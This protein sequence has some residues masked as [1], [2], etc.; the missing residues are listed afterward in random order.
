MNYI[1][2][3]R[4]FD[5]TQERGYQDRLLRL[6]YNGADYDERFKPEVWAGTGL[7]AVDMYDTVA[8]VIYEFKAE[9]VDL[10]KPQKHA[11][12]YTDMTPVQQ[13][14]HYVRGIEVTKVVVSNKNIWRVYIVFGEHAQ[15]IDECDIRTA[16]QYEFDSFCERM[17][18]VDVVNSIVNAPSRKEDTPKV[19]V[20]IE[21][22]VNESVDS[23][24]KDEVEGKRKRGA[25]K[26]ALVDALNDACDKFGIDTVAHAASARVTYFYPI[27]YKD[28]KESDEYA[29][30][31]RP[32]WMRMGDWW[33]D[34]GWGQ[35]YVQVIF[36]SLNKAFGTDYRLD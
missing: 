33:V 21:S 17:F 28:K 14:L 2:N 36:D 5:F 27:F 22:V 12:Q 10:D 1:E 18:R 8:K 3:L 26:K 34:I 6:V 13:A 15:Q 35:Q 9:S 23:A 16:R 31:W 20:V 25:I 7:G 4:K 30:K 24:P 11:K 32:T 29:G 19:E